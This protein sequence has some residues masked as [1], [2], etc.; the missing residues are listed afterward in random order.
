MKIRNA[1]ADDYPSVICV[2]NEWWGGRR[3]SD[4]LP[5]LFFSH[6]QNTSFINESDGHIQAFLVGFLSQSSLDEAYIHFAGVH[7]DNRNKGIGRR[8]YNHFFRK[9]LNQKR[10]IIRCVTSPINK[11]SI[12]FHKSMGFEL[13]RGDSEIDSIPFFSDYDGIGEHRVLFTKKLMN[14]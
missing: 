2:L 3:M 9:A 6:F 8:M 12:N 13:E 14:G 4:M 7:P 10:T 5:R 11:A 1:R